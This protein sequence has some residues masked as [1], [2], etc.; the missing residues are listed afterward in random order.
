MSAGR[1]GS[2]LI[3][4]AVVT[5]AAT[6]WW[7]L[8]GEGTRVRRALGE[9]AATVSIPAGET[10]LDR[11]ARVRRA[12]LQCTEDI[13]VEIDARVVIEGREALA[14]AIAGVRTP[15]P[16]RVAFRDVAV[17]VE[18]ASREA[19]VTATVT[20]E[21]QDARSGEAMLEAREVELRWRLIDGRWLLAAASLRPVLR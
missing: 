16:V 2:V 8:P 9:L 3:A 10:E 17:R 19:D 7:L 12:A 4:T 20:V 11:L 14:G 13:R 15:G 1:R 18:E 6:Y 5:G 21:M